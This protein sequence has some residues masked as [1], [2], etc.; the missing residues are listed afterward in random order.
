[1]TAEG[2][3]GSGRSV[4]DDKSNRLREGG[5]GRPHGDCP[6]RMNNTLSLSLSS[7]SLVIFGVELR[8]N[9]AIEE[10]GRGREKRERETNAITNYALVSRAV[11]GDSG[12]GGLDERGE[13]GERRDGGQRNMLL[14]NIVD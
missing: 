3:G 4:G 8:D 5:A 7:L 10:R 11:R 9:N 12:Q 6:G 14:H 1:M 13:E 2:R